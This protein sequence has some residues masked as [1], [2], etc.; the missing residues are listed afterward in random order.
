MLIA[1]F[2]HWEMKRHRHFTAPAQRSAL[3][4]LKSLLTALISWA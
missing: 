3:Q 2:F 1:E 4:L